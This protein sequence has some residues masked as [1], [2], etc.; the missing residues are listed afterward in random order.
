MGIREFF[1][2]AFGDMKRSAQAQHE[3]DKA[4]FAAAK[5]EARADFEAHRGSVTFQQAKADAKKSWDDIA[6]WVMPSNSAMAQTHSSVSISE[7][8]IFTLV[9]SPNILNKSERSHSSSSVGSSW[10]TLPNIS[11][12][13]CIT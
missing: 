3:V 5:A 12:W 13:L 1:R 11:S 7:K 9:V 4:N 8:R 2:K 10:R 6:D